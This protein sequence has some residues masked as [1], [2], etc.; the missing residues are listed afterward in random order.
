[1]DESTISLSHADDIRPYR[2]HVSSKYLE[3]TTK[4][5]EL[6]RLPHELLLPQSQEWE[7]GTPKSEVEPLVDFCLVRQPHADRRV[8]H[9][10]RLEKYSW[11]DREE[12]LNTTIPQYRTT[13]TI[14][15]APGPYR[16][17]FI[18]VTSPR[19]N[20]IPLLLLP[21][22]PLTNF[23]LEPLL[24]PLADPETGTSTPTFHVVAPS[25]PGLGFSDAFT[26]ASDATAAVLGD[27]AQIF[28][29]LMLRLGYEDYL[30]SGTGSG[31]TSPASI[32]YQLPRLLASKYPKNCRGIHIINPPIP[33][34]TL[35]SSFATWIRY[36]IA[37][38]F[39]VPIFG[40]TAV[41]W[42]ALSRSRR[43]YSSRPQ[44]RSSQDPEAQA[45]APTLMST[46]NGVRNVGSNGL[47]YRAIGLLGLREPNTLAYALC[48]SPVGLLSLMLNGLRRLSPDH[49]LSRSDVIDLTYLAWLPGPE[50]AMRY[51]S[52]AET[53]IQDGDTG[54]IPDWSETPTAVTVFV[55]DGQGDDGQGDNSLSRGYICPAW[56]KARHNVV[57]VERREG[58]GGLVAWERTNAVVDG[59]RSLAGE[60]AKRDKRLMGATLAEEMDDDD[61]TTV[62]DERESVRRGGKGVSPVEAGG[63]DTIV[64]SSFPLILDEL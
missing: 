31:S 48:D 44:S 52:S 10:K 50:A 11:R 59:I 5:L 19:E 14:P 17:H 42:E 43:S 38:L 36:F 61:S 46:Q 13:I 55:G 12:H 64:P 23:A 30:C 35:S 39:Q 54:N 29:A 60:V 63:P 47:A 16:V 58:R 3:L 8:V 32:D 20:A 56:A 28:N 4:K 24:T 9:H 62:I 40:Y 33:E 49:K 1:M 45:G 15:A 7:Q 37:R 21:A 51:W 22:F 34:P 26:P 25:I 18:H 53:E 27:T 6:T 41:D 2:V 57:W